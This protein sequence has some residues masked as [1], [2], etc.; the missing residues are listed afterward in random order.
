[1]C[2]KE[3]SGCDFR[4]TQ[5]T[6]I[7]GS[8]LPLRFSA[9]VLGGVYFDGITSF[10]LGLAIKLLVREM[11]NTS[12]PAVG[13]EITFDGMSRRTVTDFPGGMPGRLSSFCS[14]NESEEVISAK[15]KIVGRINK[16]IS[17]IRR[18]RQSIIHDL[19]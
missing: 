8:D 3:Y 4:A 10:G 12:L 9:S 1:M 6:V 7:D 19:Q 15:T 17:I 14:G 16:K 5:K 2:L 11:K 18:E 13:R